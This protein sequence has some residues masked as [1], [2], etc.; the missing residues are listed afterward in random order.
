MKLLEGD[1][2]FSEQIGDR[3][4]CC[5]TA[6]HVPASWL[7]LPRTGPWLTFIRP[8]GHDVG[9]PTAS[10]GRC[11]ADRSLGDFLRVGEVGKLC[12]SGHFPSR[13]LFHGDF[14]FLSLHRY[15]FLHPVHD[16]LI[17]RFPIQMLSK[18]WVSSCRGATVSPTIGHGFQVRYLRPSFASGIGRRQ[19]SP[20]PNH[21]AHARLKER[22]VTPANMKD[23]WTLDCPQR[24]SLHPQR[25]S[26]R[27]MFLSCRNLDHGL[28]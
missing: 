28:R 5:E 22:H 20:L 26:P 21:N 25:T 11:A 2:S 9:G 4:P 18:L 17:I 1:C 6:R 14:H 12:Q 7:L 27:H 19:S 3:P 8:D 13:P 24:T 23:G 16:E 15:F 10:I